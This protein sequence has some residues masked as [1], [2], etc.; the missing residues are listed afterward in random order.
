MATRPA[1]SY[2]PAPVLEGVAK[3]VP[4][5]T[6]AT[7]I[8]WSSVRHPDAAGPAPVSA[9]PTPVADA[10]PVEMSIPDATDRYIKELLAQLNNP[11]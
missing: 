11:G 6:A 2:T 8:D 7:D 1:V 5:T 9:A 10:A 3:V 4:D